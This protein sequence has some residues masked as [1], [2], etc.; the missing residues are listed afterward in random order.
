MRMPLLIM[1]C[2]MLVLSGCGGEDSSV[3]G[4]NTP[5][6]ESGNW[7]RPKPL[8]TWQ[9]QLNGEINTSYDVEMYDIDLFD[10]S[11]ELI[12]Q[13]QAEGKKVIC[14]F[15]AGSYEDWRPD[16]HRFQN[17][18]LG[19][20]LDGW[21]GERWLD[22]RSANVRE[23][24]KSRFDLAAQKGCDGVEPDNVDGYLNNSG[25]SLTATDQLAFNRFIANE[26]HKKGL[27]VGLKNDLDQV[28]ELVSYFDFALTEQC[29]EYSECDALEP[30]ITAGKA[31]LNVEYKAG[32]VNDQDARNA[33]CAE[34]I[35]R[36]FSTL[37]LPID[38]NDEFRLSC[39]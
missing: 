26:A 7:Y 24:M 34:S 5:P 27:C 4:L 35:N 11:E 38:L 23:I 33:L 37:I 1:V 12:Q 29:F 19:N 14:Y 8:V 2:C 13:L 32:Y 15:S 20:P 10:S 16:A 31:V 9:W 25:F 22:I 17:A 6:I 39:F 3:V 28:N 18:E 36:Q 30:F 21:P